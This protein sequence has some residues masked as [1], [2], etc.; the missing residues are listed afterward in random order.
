MSALNPLDFALRVCESTAFCLHAILGPTEPYTGCLRGAFNDKGT[1]GGMPSWFWPTAGALLLVVAI[2]NFS[3]SNAVVLAAQAYIAA[4]HT[5]A[6]FYHLKLGHH[7]ASGCAPAFFVVMAF[8]VTW[9]RTGILVA[10]LGTGV[11][12]AIALGLSK[13]LVIHPPPP[14]DADIGR[15]SQSHLL[16]PTIQ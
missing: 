4:F 15:N 1:N 10:M 11:C 6:V 14:N 13:I 12:I 16:R 5:G 9:L 7:P 2:A 8:I 3:N